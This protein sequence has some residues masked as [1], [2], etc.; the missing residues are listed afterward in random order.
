[1]MGKRIPVEKD[2]DKFFYGGS[3]G[4]N[5]EEEEL[6]DLAFNEASKKANAAELEGDVVE[7]QGRWRT[8]G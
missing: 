7:G 1:M 5:I 8:S 4:R 2:P 6:I 3:G